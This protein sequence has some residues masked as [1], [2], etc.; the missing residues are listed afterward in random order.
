MMSGMLIIIGGC[1]KSKVMGRYS[2]YDTRR[3][4]DG[5]LESG[6]GLYDGQ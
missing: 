5:E 1:M 3:A 4:V 2:D 6:H